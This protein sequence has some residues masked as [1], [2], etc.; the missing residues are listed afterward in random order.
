MA[1]LGTWLLL[2]GLIVGDALESFFAETSEF[3]FTESFTLLED[4]AGTIQ[5]ALLDIYVA[6]AP[7]CSPGNAAEMVADTRFGEAAADDRSIDL[8][9]DRRHDLGCYPGLAVG[10]SRVGR[11]VCRGQGL[12]PGVDGA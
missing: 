9:V 8:V 12:G 3:S 7:S 6:Y 5:I 4:L 10:I 2:G 11:R 1:V